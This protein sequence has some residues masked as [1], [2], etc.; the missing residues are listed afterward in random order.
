MMEKEVAVKL[1]QSDLV[2]LIVILETELGIESAFPVTIK[3]VA[4]IGELDKLAEG[5]GQNVRD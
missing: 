3:L 1:A 5:I 4:A 2:A